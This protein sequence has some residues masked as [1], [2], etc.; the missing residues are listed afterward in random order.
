MLLTT[1]YTAQISSAQ[2]A[3]IP[4][5]I[6][7]ACHQAQPLPYQNIIAIISSGPGAVAGPLSSACLFPPARDS[8]LGPGPDA[9]KALP[10]TGIR[11]APW[12][13]AG[14]DGAPVQGK[15]GPR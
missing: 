3:I 14:L 2:N 8:D 15:A 1:A 12:R 6:S 4:T 10:P 11:S 5:H 13:L 7:P 9:R